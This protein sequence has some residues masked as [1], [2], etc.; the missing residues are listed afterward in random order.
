MIELAGRAF[1]DLGDY[2][3]IIADWLDAPR[4][5]SLILLE[6]EHPVGFALIARHTRLGFLRR[7]TAELVA[8]VL[9]SQARGRGLG[10]VLLEAA[11]SEATRFAASEMWLHTAEDN[12][13]AREFFSARGYAESGS[14]RAPRRYP[15]G[16]RA[17]EF[18]RTLLD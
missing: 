18:R 7:P 15:H 11:E 8:L 16:Q 12:F 1:E 17:L 10:R 5:T 3:T 14:G 9:E 4:V 2:F 13:R 6:Q